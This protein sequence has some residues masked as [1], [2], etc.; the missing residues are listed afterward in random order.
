MAELARALARKKVER[1]PEE[2]LTPLSNRLFPN[3][4]LEAVVER[5]SRRGESSWD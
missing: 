1:F 2:R 4:T 5:M 3:P